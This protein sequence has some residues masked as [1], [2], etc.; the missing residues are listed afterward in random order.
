MLNFPGQDT[1]DIISTGISC[2]DNL[3][4]HCYLLAQDNPPVVTDLKFTLE[5]AVWP[6]RIPL[7]NWDKPVIIQIAGLRAM[8][9]PMHWPRHG[10]I[11]I[12]TY[13]RIVLDL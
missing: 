5:W 4:I 9:T 12:L 7:L 13:T 2:N 3:I 6:M 8:R 1:G 11:N 10:L